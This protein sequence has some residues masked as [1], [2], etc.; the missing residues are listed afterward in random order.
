MCI[1]KYIYLFIYVNKWINNPTS[2]HR[3]SALLDFLFPVLT[4]LGDGCLDLADLGAHP[5]GHHAGQAG[6]VGDRGAREEQVL[7]LLGKAGKAGKAGAWVLGCWKS[8][9]QF[10]YWARVR[11]EGQIV[12]II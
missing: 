6:T 12:S 5:G 3:G 7:L 11:S 4:S 9:S 8:D 2:K 1:Y 10:L